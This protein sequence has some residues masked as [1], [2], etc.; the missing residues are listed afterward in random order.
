MKKKSFAKQNRSFLCLLSLQIVFTIMILLFCDIKYEVSDDFIMSLIAS[1][2]FNGSPSPYIM[3][4]NVLYGALLTRLYQLASSVNWYFWLQILISFLSLGAVSYVISR[5]FSLSLSILI[6]CI[7]Y[8]FAAQDLFILIQFTKTAATAICSGSILF[9]WGT[10]YSKSKRVSIVGACLVLI[11]SLVRFNC[12]YVAAPFVLLCLVIEG[13]RIWKL[14][15]DKTDN[16]SFDHSCLMR[17]ASCLVLIFIVFLLHGINS[18]AYRSNDQ[19]KYFKDYSYVR[20]NIVDYERPDY[21]ICRDELAAIGISENDYALLDSWNFS[22]E[23]V[24]SLSKMKEILAI[25]RPYRHNNWSISFLLKN[26][27][28]RGCI[29]YYIT[30]CCILLGLLSVLL[31]KKYGGAVSILCAACVFGLLSYFLAIG[32]CIYR[33]EF[34]CFYGAACVILLYMKADGLSDIRNLNF[35]QQAFL[36]KAV[37]VFCLAASVIL[38]LV[39]LPDYKPDTTFASLSNSQYLDYVDVTFRY[40][41]NY[42]T[43]KYTKTVNKRAIRGEFL[44]EINS[45]PDNLYLLDF[46][47]VIQTLYFDFSPLVAIQPNSFSNALY[48]GGVTLHHPS[49]DEALAQ[50]GFDNPM[51]ALLSNSVYLVSN[52]NVEKIA[53]FLEEHY[54]I[55]VHT[56]LYKTT[57]DYQIWKLSTAK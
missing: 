45:H 12:I 30:S 37:S 3:F 22:D 40:D 47:T 33:V 55:Q 38:C 49:L 19:L 16:L 13:I 25:I 53:T 27:K 15:H 14:R 7:F 21:E 54:N 26:L 8:L 28:D 18:L 51:L 2:A 6:F 1:G 17:F 52:T 48:L 11:G 36:K 32:R 24:F 29:H 23:S 35:L 31:N 43:D 57:D 5:K 46:S 44:N 10:F 34:G 20:A 50:Y 56:Q 41:W 9:L 42:N 39:K 4:P